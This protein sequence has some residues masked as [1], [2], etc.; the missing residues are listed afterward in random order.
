[1]LP[2]KIERRLPLSLFLV[3][4][5]CP[6]S[7]VFFGCSCIISIS[8]SRIFPQCLCAPIVSVFKPP[9]FSYKDTRHWVRTHPNP[10]W[11]HLTLD[12]ICRNLQ[13]SSVAQSCPTLCDPMDYSTPGFPGKLLELCQTHI[14]WVGDAIQP[15]HPLLSPSPPAFNLSQHQGLFQWVSSSNQVA[16]VLDFQL[17]HQSCQWIFRTDFGWTGWIS[18]QSKGLSRVFSNTTVQKHQFFSTQ[19]SLQK[20]YFRIKI[21]FTNN[22]GSDLKHILG[23]ETGIHNSSHTRDC[24]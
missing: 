23:Q 13:L 15:S 10:V 7:F 4:S 20:P 17:Q 3:S 1:M 21:T 9:S 8:A 12:K 11:P 19:L 2:L 6:Q 16:K 24:L 22:K 18:L 14:H 5:G